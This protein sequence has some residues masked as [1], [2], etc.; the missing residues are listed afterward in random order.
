M[1]TMRG[2]DLIDLGAEL[3]PRWLV[4]T[5]VV[6]VLGFVMVMGNMAPI[7]WYVQDKAAG[8][9]DVMQ[10]FTDEWIQQFQVSIA[11]SQAPAPEPALRTFE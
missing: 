10:G 8:L 4:R 2:S 1:I 3:L 9:T 5:V 7:A 6:S 11:P